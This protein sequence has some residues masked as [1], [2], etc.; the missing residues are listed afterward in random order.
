MKSKHNGLDARN[1]EV[2][3]ANIVGGPNHIV[4]E[5]Y[6]IVGDGYHNGLRSSHNVFCSRNIVAEPQPIVSGASARN[7]KRRQEDGTAAL[8]PLRPV[9]EVPIR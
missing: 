4:G 9:A 3:L 2:V 5:L 6:F 1:N 8:V 7:G